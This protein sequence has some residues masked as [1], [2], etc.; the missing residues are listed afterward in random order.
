MQEEKK[1]R[2][3]ERGDRERG[4]LER[5]FEGAEIKKQVGEQRNGVLVIS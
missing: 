1:K 3:D 2:R 5:V 4:D